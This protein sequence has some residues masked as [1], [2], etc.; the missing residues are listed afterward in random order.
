MLIKDFCPP[1]AKIDFIKFNVRPPIWNNLGVKNDFEA[2]NDFEKELLKNGGY[3]R[4]SCRPRC[5]QYQDVEIT[6]HDPSK[7][8]LQFLVNEYPDTGIRELEIA[9]D[10]FLKDGSNDPVRL[11]GFH[12][13]LKRRLY[14]QRHIMMKRGRRKFYDTSD[15]SIKR[16]TL[17]T[18]SGNETIYWQDADCIQKVRLYIK[19]KDNHKPIKKRCVRLEVTLTQSA[20]VR[21][22]VDRI[23]MLPEFFEGMRRY[24]SPFFNV[25]KGIKP[26][27]K[28][29]R[30]ITPKKQKLAD[31]EAKKEQKR[32]ERNWKRFGAAWAVEHGYK[33]APDADTNRLIGAALKGLQNR[34]RL[35][36][37]EKVDECIE[38]FED[39]VIIN[40]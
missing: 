4:V 36:M 24:L 21:L 8:G 40:K 20:C 38:Y 6:V 19:T 1:L 23:W 13:C 39:L 15:K 32:V 7:E 34:M 2:E 28:R 14:P 11:I 25:A 22:R 10:F 33:I 16:D 9:I 29:S 17:K 31:L 27:I 35:K 37:T 18:R 3:V 26:R 30:F 12:D 5:N